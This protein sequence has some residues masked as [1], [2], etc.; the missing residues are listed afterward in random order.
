L[1]K[2]RK[3]ETRIILF[4]I[5]S[6]SSFLVCSFRLIIVKGEQKNYR[7]SPPEKWLSDKYDS[8][9]ECAALL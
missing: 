1:K 5:D 9:L 8:M 3:E 2:R 6:R 4:L 7:Y